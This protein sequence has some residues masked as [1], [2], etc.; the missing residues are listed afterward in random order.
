[1]TEK[2]LLLV[3]GSS[4]LY[5]AFHA[6]PDLRNADGEP[7]GAIYGMVGMLRRLRADSK[8]NG[9][10][11]HGAVVFD[12]PG[13]TFRDDIY[14]K[15]KANRPSMPPDLASQI[16]IIHEIVRAMGWPLVMIGGVEAD[17]VIGT[18]AVKASSLG[19][20]T[21]VSTGDKDMAQLV[22][23]KVTLFNTMTRDNAAIEHLDIERVREKFGVPP[24]RIVD[25]LALVGDT[26]DNVPGVE[27]CGPKTA[28]KWL[29]AYDSLDGV[30]ANAAAIKGKVGEN[31]RAA[32]NF[33]PTGR[34]LVT[35]CTD[36]ELPA[37]LTDFDAGLS[38]AAEDTAQLLEL[39][40]RAGFK[41]WLREVQQRLGVSGSDAGMAAS[42][43]VESVSHTMPATTEAECVTTPEAFAVWLERIGAVDLVAFDT[44][45]TSLIA[46]QAE[47]VGL[48]LSVEP[49]K[50]CY[51]PVA[52]CYPGAP[53]QLDRDWVLD[54][55]RDWLQD[56]AAAKVGQNLKYDAHVLANYGIALAGIA[57]D[58]LL[59]SYVL[60]AHRPHDMDSLAKR[61]LGRKTI[62]YT[63]VAGKGAKQIRF[64]QVALEQ[65]TDYAAEDADVTLQLHRV[66]YPQ[67]EGDEKLLSVYRDIE[68][69][70]LSALRQ[71][72]RNGVLIDPD[73]LRAQSGQIGSRLLELEQKAYEVAGQPFNLGSPKQL[74]EILF[75]K[76]ELPVVK[77]TASGQPSTD[78]EVLSKL[79]QDYPLPKLVLEHRSLSKLKGTY[80]DKLPAM[81]HP[82]TGRVHTNYAQATA[83]TGRLASTDPNLQNIP[84]R[85]LEG[86]RIRE[87]FIAPAQALIVSCDY[88]QIELRIMAHI[89]Q[90]AGLVAAFEQGLDVHRATA[91]EVF[92][93][94]LDQVDAEQRRYAKVINFGLIYGMSAFGLARNLNIERSAAASYIERY[95]ARYPGVADYM[96]KT[97]AL[98][99]QQGYVET[100]FGRRLWL[101][102]IN[103]PNGPRRQGAERAAINAPMQGTAADLI[104]MAMVKV[105]DWLTAESLQSLIIMQVHDE[106]VLEVPQVELE[107]VREAVPRLMSQAASLRVPLLVEA[108]V[109]PNWEQAH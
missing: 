48:S 2:T 4:Y 74:G 65:A 97:R 85:T 86:R 18:L 44:E 27:K 13:K 14:D 72:E 11:G 16:P 26:V 50:A 88:S 3:D 92:S 31:L 23:D 79:A 9:G 39:F 91:A 102:E 36:V 55:L 108:G 109:G 46:M 25:Y 51:I 43:G 59:Q 96:E 61:H 81:I 105:Q 28:V 107:L 42:P 99:K 29:A 67:I 5:R 21:L 37:E 15:Y 73:A 33:L 40:E 32:L 101:P 98:A 57:H 38:L 60:E 54:Q 58:T 87:A 84:V 70:S 8:L 52:H 78:E 24:D 6:L 34:E 7:T 35:I 62:S 103:S 63:E 100:V 47:L 10:A 68:L 75:G 95:F 94:S 89:S 93:V 76:L 80:T 30:I 64:D 22:N 49:G 77:K 20:R 106:L 17:D 104:K 19:A 90:D 82:L 71:I 41:T 45:T 56:P 12:A 66:L 1:M 83:V 53:D 69:P